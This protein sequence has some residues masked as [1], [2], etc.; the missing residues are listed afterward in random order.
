MPR[1]PSNALPFAEA[2]AAN[3]QTLA[4]EVLPHETDRPGRWRLRPMNV[5]VLS[6]DD[7]GGGFYIV[8][9]LEVSPTG[10][11]RPCLMDIA[12]PER[13]NDY[14]YFVDG[15]RVRRIR[16]HQ[17]AGKVIPAI[18]FDCFG[19][20]ETFYVRSNPDVGLDVLRW[21]LA[22]ATR[23]RFIAQD[24]AYILRDEG[25]D[26]AAADLFEVV[27][28]EQAPS[29]F[30]FGELASLYKRLGK[31]ERERKYQSLYDSGGVVRRKQV[32]RSADGRR[33]ASG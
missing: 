9:A 32:T 22:V 11:V 8:R 21:G 2:V 13:I 24:A 10:K 29:Y 15:G 6:D 5:R 14:S 16:T 20:Y 25:Q 26:Q 18:A 31:A 4:F 19:N 23:K 12:Y 27:V 3:P 33:A 7:S 1:S 30:T 28:A 17:C